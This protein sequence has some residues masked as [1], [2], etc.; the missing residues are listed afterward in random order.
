MMR[1]RSRW[2]AL[3]ALG[4]VSVGLGATFGGCSTDSTTPTVRSLERAGRAAFFCAGAPGSDAALRPLSDCNATQR[5]DVLDFGDDKSLAHLYALV[6]LETR[7]EL[8]VIDLTSD[9]N[10]VLDADPSI[11]GENPLPVGAQP[12]EVVVTPKGTAAFVASAEL[13][14]PAIY[15]IPGEALRPCEVDS[16]RCSQPALTLSSLPACRLPSTPSAMV[17]V[18]DRPDADGNVRATCDGSYA[19]LAGDG[20]AY[21]DIDRE[22][23]GRQKLF[24]ALPKE[25]RV[26]V[27]DAQS[28]LESPPG[29]V[30]DCVLEDVGLPVA[31]TSAVPPISVDAPDSGE[32]GCAPPD[33]GD[34][35]PST[36]LG[37]ATPSSLALFQPPSGVAGAGGAKLFVGDL[38]LPLIHVLDLGDPCNASEAAPL[39]PSSSEDPS[40]VV[41]T[42]KLAVSPITPSN[43][44]Y[45]YA[46]D[47]EDRSLMTFDVSPG[48]SPLP[49]SRPNPE[50]NPFQPA[51]R[52]RF[53][54]APSDVNIIVRDNPEAAASG[55]APFGTLCDPDPN[56]KVCSSSSQS[57]D[58]GTF[59]RTSSDFATGAGPFTLRG[60]FGL[61]ALASGAIAVVDI[62]DFDA[63]C[64]G[65][66]LA[67]TALGCA[68]DG[69]TEQVTTDEPSCNVVAPF[70]ARS[71]SYLLTN[72][73]VGRHEPGI[74][75]FPTLSLEDGTVLEGDKAPSMRALLPAGGSSAGLRLA[76]GG[77]V[78]TPDETGAVIDDQGPRHTLLMNLEDPR[79]HQTDQEWQF[80]YRGALPGTE[81]HVGDLEYVSLTFNDPSVDFCGLGVQS[82]GSVSDS[83]LGEDLTEQQRQAQALRYA[84][85]LSITEP[86][87]DQT[88]PYWDTAS[89]SYQDCRTTF[90]DPARELR[91]VEAY[92]GRVEL[93]LPDGV[94]SDTLRCCFPTLLDYEIRP[95]DEWV[96]VG[97]A[98]GFLHHVVADPDTGKCRPS[99]D[100]RAARKVGRVRHVVSSEAIKE[101]HPN[102]FKSA[103]F[104]L[105]ILVNADNLPPRDASFRFITQSSF[106]PLRPSLTN[107]GRRSVQTQML[108]YLPTTD[109]IFV[110]DGA[111]EGL[112]MVPG[113]LVGDVRQFY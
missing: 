70:E 11:P 15:A 35:R 91:I 44:Q 18:A 36:G 3:S 93:A 23:E 87:I 50:R 100:A 66:S 42:D 10:N 61:V 26:V 4:L 88:D 97:G 107:D 62:E 72:D 56:A 16:S 63:P 80:T 37:E 31:L 54:A 55:A 74:Q 112:L 43:K 69:S 21:G 13:S 29:D 85:R 89:C 75:T 86:L 2:L 41:L 106:V 46:V 9:E 51:D 12:V 28:L 7:G 102:A 32:P 30:A 25:H 82:E 64:R 14:R 90:T 22:G 103:L 57:C 8:A 33:L 59:Y 5:A 105:A 24:V 98:S 6:T 84:D 94:S 19:P 76:V 48:A 68:A 101:D 78:F 73:D 1:S 96:A 99:C 58:L 95:G 111:L 49:I 17:M 67:S 27:I 60:V 83:L 104:K 81:F 52:L 53:A 40:R 38:S 79:V 45:L 92:Q 109:E 34:A 39:L 110:T 71:S 108:G 20:P 77:E 47:V 65:P 113:D